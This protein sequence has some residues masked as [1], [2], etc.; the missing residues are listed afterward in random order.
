MWTL[1][2]LT[3][4]ISPWTNAPKKVA[5]PQTFAIV[6]I[7]SDIY[8]LIM[9]RTHIR[10]SNVTF[11]PTPHVTHRQKLYVGEYVKHTK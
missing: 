1:V 11:V 10:P 8:A 9:C 6:N 5:L 4:V 7:T 2:C 3:A